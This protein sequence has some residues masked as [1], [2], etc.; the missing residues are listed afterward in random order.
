MSPGWAIDHDCALKK[1]LFMDKQYETNL[2][3]ADELNVLFIGGDD[4]GKWRKLDT[5]IDA[6][7]SYQRRFLKWGGKYFAVFVHV[8]LDEASI[9]QSL[10]LG[11][12]GGHP[13]ALEYP[14]TEKPTGRSFDFSIV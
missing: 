3:K 12:K 6:M 8:D 11:Y 2:G 4:D 5:R 14:T 1:G 10:I 9:L 7:L 13:G